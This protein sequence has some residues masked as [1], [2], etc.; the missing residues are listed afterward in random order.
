MKLS[1]TTEEIADK[2]TFRPGSRGYFMADE[3]PIVI[4]GE[5]DTHVWTILDRNGSYYGIFKAPE[6]LSAIH[7][8]SDPGGRE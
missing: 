6:N 5:D 3:N 8:T 2:T 1:V 4:V 7:I